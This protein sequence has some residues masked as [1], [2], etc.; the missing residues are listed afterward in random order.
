MKASVWMTTAA[1]AAWG[2]TG[3]VGGRDLARDVV[4]GGLGP[5][6]AALVTHAI[7]VRTVATDLARLQSRL[8]AGFAAKA[9]FFAFYV[10]VALRVAQADAMPF[11]ASFVLSFLAFHVTEAIF[12]Q[13]LTTRRVSSPAAS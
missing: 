12:L 11:V 13:R 4:L 2:L 9:V 8:L 6:A 10:V 5:L 1:V 3:L 7:I